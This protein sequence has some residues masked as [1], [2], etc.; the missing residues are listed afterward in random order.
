[1]LE[2]LADPILPIYAALVVGYLLR[3][4]GVMT[5]SDAVA[6]NRFA[7]YLAVPALV[8]GVIA[9]SP[10][11][12]FNWTAIGGYFLSELTMFAAVFA[13][14]HYTF[15]RE[16]LESILLG[17]ASSFVN[18]IFFVLPIAE[19][20]IG[21]DAGLPMAGIVMLDAG[22][23]FSGTVVLV[24]L[25]QAR[26]TGKT[27]LA[28]ILLKNPFIYAP[29]AGILLGLAGDAAPSGI[30]TFAEFA[31]AAAAPVLLFTLG[32]TLAGSTF[33]RM[34]GA[35]WAVVGGKLLVHPLIVWAMLRL[36]GVEG[37]SGD[38]TLLVAAGP[39]GAMPFVIATQYGIKTETLA[40]VVLASTTLSILSILSITELIT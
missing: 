34:S 6:I 10:I 39:C 17:M 31:G 5:V 1:M 40:K 19:R 33:W 29:P 12:D 20:L 16:L 37:L 2:T 22:V 21:P 24:A 3:R 32:I 8:V 23:L 38:I 13:L 36:G 28:G 26:E 30:M 27:G 11:A 15:R 18:H 9:K 14:V 35:G 4:A 25:I 7:F